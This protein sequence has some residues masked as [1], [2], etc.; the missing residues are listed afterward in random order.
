MGLPTAQDIMDFLQ[1][2]CLDTLAIAGSETVTVSDIT[3]LVTVAGGY[4]YNTGDMVK[5][6]AVT[7]IPAPLVL[8]EMYYLIE[9]TPLTFKLATSRDNAD[10]GTFI[11]ITSTGVG[12]ITMSKYDYAYINQ[13][14]IEKR[15][16]NFVVPYVERVT[17]QSFGSIKSVVQFYSGNGKNY[18][19]LNKKPIVALTEIRYV[20][21]GSNFTI[22]N[23][24]N[25]QVVASEGILKAKRNYEEAYYLPVFARGDYNIQITYTYGYADCPEDV[26]EAVM[27]LCAE[28]ILGFIGARTGGGSLTMQSYGRNYGSRGKYQ[29]IRNDLSRQAYAL[30]SPYMTSVVG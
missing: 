8:A 16:D 25:I 10:A 29:D 15:R 18:L 13:S 6:T 17:R 21:G 11:D 30:L 28:Q 14:W 4:G 3:N 7:S 1:G 20:L 2:Y 27:Y 12:T 9:V 26:K 19:L 22:L 24:Q 23:L 5:F